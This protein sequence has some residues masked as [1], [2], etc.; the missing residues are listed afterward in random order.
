MMRFLARLGLPL[1]VVVAVIFSNG[2]ASYTT[3]AAA[4]PGVIDA[5]V[6]SWRGSGT[7]KSHADAAPEAVNCK[8]RYKLMDAENTLR[9]EVTCAA[10]NGKGQLVGF[11]KYTENSSQISGNWYR[12]WSTSEG[13]ENGTFTGTI[14]DT[15]IEL[16]VSAAGKVRAHLTMIPKSTTSH[17][18]SLVGIVDGIPQQGMDITFRN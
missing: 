9:V 17:D 16:K 5:L 10:A 18:V 11:I 12:K 8:A 4:P 13:E 3:A 15:K 2:L 1:A 6:G 7:A 14:S